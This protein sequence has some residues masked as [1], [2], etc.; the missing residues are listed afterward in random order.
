MFGSDGQVVEETEAWTVAW[1]RVMGPSSCAAGQTSLQSYFSRQHSPT[2]RVHR[3]YDQPR[4]QM[5]GGW[6]DN[7]HSIF[8]CLSH[9]FHSGSVSLC[10][11]SRG[12]LFS[13]VPARLWCHWWNR[14]GILWCEHSRAILQ[15][16]FQGPTP[17]V[18][19]EMDTMWDKFHNFSIYPKTKLKGLTHWHIFNSFIISDL[20]YTVQWSNT[21]INYTVTY[22]NYVLLSSYMHKIA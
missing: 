21:M 22:W 13:S 3:R 14:G 2:C 15:R 4:I 9:R 5:V 17:T 12:N 7:I 20:F 8:R 18:E 11:R 10:L 1:K 6:G 19:K 16:L